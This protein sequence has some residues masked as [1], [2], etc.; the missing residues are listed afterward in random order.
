[1]TRTY[2]RWRRAVLDERGT[3]LVAA[4][5]LL[6]SFTAAA[7]ILLARDYDQR[8]A[9]RSVAQAVAFQAARAGAQQIDVEVVRRD[10]LV[11]LDREAAEEQARLTAQRLLIDQGETG[12][13]IVSIEADRV[14]VVVE[15]VDVIEGGVEGSRTAV[16]RA[17][18]AAR[19]IS[20]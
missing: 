20:G 18:G 9:T 6:F 3:A 8:I 14:L 19:A 17:E 13:V 12:T 15:I 11:V 5:I 4:T 7:M 10:G 16:V 1:M 2:S